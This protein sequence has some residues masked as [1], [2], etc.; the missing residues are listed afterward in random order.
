MWTAGSIIRRIHSCLVLPPMVANDDIRPTVWNVFTP[1]TPARLAFVERDTLNERLVDALRTPGK[2]IVVYGHS[3]SGKTTLVVNKLHQLYD[4]HVT[5]RCVRG[6]TFEA[7]ILDA[8]DQLNGFYASTTQT[9]TKKG[10]S[11]SLAP[12]YALI[13]ME[14]GAVRSTDHTTTTQRVLPPQLTV[15]NLARFLGASGACWVLED[16]HKLL[17]LEKL[18][19]AQALKV[20]MDVADNYPA[21]KVIALGAV[22]TA[23]EVIDWEPE[24]TARLAQVHVPLMDN[25][26]IV[27]IVAKGEALLNLRFPQRL[28]RGIVRYS[29]GL[30][31]VCHQLCLNI[32]LAAGVDRVLPEQVELPREC[33]DAALQRYID[34]CSDTLK[35]CFDRALRQKTAG[36]YADAWLLIKALTSFDHE[37]APVGSMLRAIREQV[38]EY[39]K[40]NLTRWLRTL[41]SEQRGALLIHDSASGKYR[42]SDPIFRVFAMANP[43]ELSTQ[44][45]DAEIL[46]DLGFVDAD[47]VSKDFTRLLRAEIADDL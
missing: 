31:A 36:R 16:F 34:D 40:S 27:G 3:G 10:L 38:P 13:K 30:A 9:V 39:P 28:R 26:E 35:E 47:G 25:R 20:F 33:L 45:T 29:S 43:L 11:A 24:M 32:C 44:I 22:S 21:V 12:L 41:Q 46:S 8:F 2:Q 14:L 7:L 23:R 4:H 6:L 18:K 15:Q 42:F 1:T 19:M 5:S 37:G 17:D